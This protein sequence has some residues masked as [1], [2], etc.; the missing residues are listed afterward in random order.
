MLCININPTGMTYVTTFNKIFSMMVV[1]KK[2]KK[3]TRAV[4]PKIKNTYFFL[5]TCS[6]IINLYYFGAKTEIFIYLL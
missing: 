4:Q 6:V 3:I 5:L 2:K 1:G